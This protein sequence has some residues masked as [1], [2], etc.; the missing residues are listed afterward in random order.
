[1]S[2]EELAEKYSIHVTSSSI[3]VTNL[4]LLMG[5]L[6]SGVVNLSVER[7]VTRS[8]RKI[9]ILRLAPSEDELDKERRFYVAI[10]KGARMEVM[11]DEKPKFL[12]KVNKAVAEEETAYTEFE[13]LWT[14][15][16]STYVEDRIREIMRE[17]PEREGFDGS[18]KIAA[19]SKTDE[20]GRFV[21][22]SQPSKL[23]PEQATRLVEAKGA[24]VI[25]AP[26][27]LYALE[28]KE[29]NMVVF[30][31][32]WEAGRFPF[33]VSLKGSNKRGRGES[34]SG[35]SK[36]AAVEKTPEEPRA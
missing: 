3:V 29:K 17:D 13:A 4:A 8:S 24:H 14:T 26:A 5:A 31:A 27:Y 34:A 20:I 32:S 9:Y 7:K 6:D 33:Q 2:Y 25:M 28:D 16:L 12:W 11:E 35:S 30:G 23:K 22:I 21:M 15:F 19:L 1:M 18:M 36:K 10:P